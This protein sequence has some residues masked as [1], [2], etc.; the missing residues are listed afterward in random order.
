MKNLTI[1]IKISGISILILGIIHLATA[2]TV[3]P[4]W[5]N[6]GTGWLS[7]FSFFYLTAGLGTILPGLIST[8]STEK[9]NDSHRRAWTII[10]I[11]S[12]Y[13]ILLGVDPVISMKGNPFAYVMLVIALSLF[14]PTIMIKKKM[15]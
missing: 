9:L 2:F 12:I 11:C 5:S 3:L 15:S 10:L 8:I 1:W 4:M 13:S 14:I 6:I 7:V